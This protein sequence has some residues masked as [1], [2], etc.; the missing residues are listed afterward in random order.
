MTKF[1]GI[2]HT[3]SEVHSS[4]K[5]SLEVLKKFNCYHHL[6]YTFVLLF[7][8]TEILYYEENILLDFQLNL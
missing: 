4:N 6:S 7:K 5:T 3:M 8:C 1:F 2:K